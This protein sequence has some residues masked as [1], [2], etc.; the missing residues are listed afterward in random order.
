M[1]VMLGV[2]LAAP[3]FPQETF[4]HQIARDNFI[5]EYNR[6]AALAAEAPDI[7]IIMSD[8]RPIQNEIVHNSLSQQPAVP[9]VPVNPAFNKFSFQANLGGNQQFLPTHATFPA[10]GHLAGHLAGHQAGHQAPLATLDSVH[11]GKWTG[12]LA[13]TVPAGVNGLPRQVT[14]TPAVQAARNAHFQAL[15]AAFQRA[16]SQSQ[17]RI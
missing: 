15:Q 16:A 7:H 13:D 6:L 9:H 8:R 14:P 12:E 10:A 5:R 17:A 11:P 4:E 3:Q 2:A 1:S